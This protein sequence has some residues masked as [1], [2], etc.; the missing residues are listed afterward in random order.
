MKVDINLIRD[1]FELV[2]PIGDQ[3]INKFY[4]NLFIDYPQIKDFFKNTDLSKQKEVLLNAL[5]TT[6]DNLD[7]TDS[8]SLFLLHLGE[9]HLNYGTNDEHYEW[10]EQTLLKT[11]S[12]FLG[13]YW[14]EELFSQWQEIYRYITK[15]LKNGAKSTINIAKE[16]EKSNQINLIVPEYSL[17]D[18]IEMPYITENIKKTVQQAVKSVILKQI[19]TEV[20]KY[21]EEEIQ[22]IMQ[23]SPEDLIEK[24]FRT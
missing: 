6:I 2:K 15:M 10:I 13:K 22:E 9:S 19:K 18:K 16:N 8:L 14:N 4:E 21:L 17:S 24:A 5:V 11:F 1:S 20:H 7:K 3:I 23:M 12:H